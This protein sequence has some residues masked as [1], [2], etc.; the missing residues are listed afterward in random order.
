MIIL[1]FIGVVVMLGFLAHAVDNLEN[2]LKKIEEKLKNK[3][4]AECQ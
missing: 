2:R 4:E 3:G 1:N